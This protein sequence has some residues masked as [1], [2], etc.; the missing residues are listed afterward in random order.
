MFKTK[1]RFNIDASDSA[2][3]FTQT[4]REHFVASVTQLEL[5]LKIWSTARI[6]SIFY[7]DSST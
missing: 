5:F 2:T 3:A 4:L 1:I 7:Q 6:G